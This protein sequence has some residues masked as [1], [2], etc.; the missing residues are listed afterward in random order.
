MKNDWKNI[1]KILTNH[2][3]LKIFRL[4]LSYRFWFLFLIN[5]FLDLFDDLDDY[6]VSV[7]LSTLL[8]DVLPP[9]IFNRS[10]ISLDRYFK[11]IRI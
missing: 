3:L 10:S 6:S 7:D 11:S 1:E 4:D 2:A 9:I 5:V 8:H